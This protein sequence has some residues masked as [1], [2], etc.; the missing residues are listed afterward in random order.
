MDNAETASSA[1]ELDVR[2][3]RPRAEYRM[4]R[5]VLLHALA[6]IYF[7]AF[8]IV[9]QQHAP[10]IGSEGLLPAANFLEH[11]QAR[12]GSKLSGFWRVPSLF[13]LGASDAALA[14]TASIGFVLAALACLGFG[15]AIVFFVLW[16]LYLSFVQVGQIFYGYGWESLLCEAGFLAIFLAPPGVV[17]FGRAAE[18]PRLLILLFRWL[19]FRVMFGAG[20]IKLRGDPCWLDLTCLVYHYETQPNPNPLSPW[21]HGLPLFTHQA[22]V[23]FNHLVE[24]VA[25]FF[26]FG[27]R[28]ARYAAGIS[29]IAFQV[30]L[31]ASGNLSFLNWLTLAV[32]LSCF[33][34]AFFRSIRARL[35]ALVSRVRIRH[36]LFPPLRGR[37]APELGPVPGRP[38][39]GRTW[40]YASYALGIAIAGLSLNPIV[41]LL[42]PRQAMNASFDPFMIVNTYGAFGSVGKVRH[43]VVFEGTASEDP[44]PEA[45]WHAYEFPCKP[46]DPE[47]SPCLISPYHYRL[48][49]QLWFL[50]FGPL[51]EQ[52]WAIHL[53]Y[54]LLKGDSGVRGLLAHDPFPDRPPRHV[55]ARY[56]SYRYARAGEPGVWHRE[57]VGEYLRPVSRNDPELLGYVQLQGW[58]E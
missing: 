32:A 14:V 7:V 51:D 2:R 35:R 54:K 26:V 21:F 39:P 50:A 4:T 58:P 12:L 15:N 22:G 29:I 24:V 34:D 56:Y 8:L 11:V 19:T 38:E 49:W 30:L 57:L 1:A 36:R 6:F 43:E 44:G 40:R 52:P 31:I 9:V 13:W 41:N 17:R 3:L 16:A 46:G 55:R 23:L 37:G 45:R 28:R 53:V 10:L 47:R 25:P 5:N 42:S 48:D 27:P 18:P 20:L 33:D